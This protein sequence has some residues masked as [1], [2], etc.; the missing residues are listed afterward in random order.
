MAA[1]AAGVPHVY[2]TITGLGY[3]FEA[4]NSSRNAST[5]WAACYTAWRFG[6]GRRFFSESGRHKGFPP[7]GHPRPQPRVLTA[8]GT[9]VDTKRFAP[10][11]LARLFRR[12]P[13]QRVACF[14][15]WWR[16]CLKPRAC[17]NMPK[18][19]ACSMPGT[20]MPAFRCS[21]RRKKASAA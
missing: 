4:D 7:V 10:Q 11:P 3:A 16:A 15:C 9:G 8:R 17:R 1:R 12:W 5:A 20:L 2:A 13:P 19:R 21:A 6:R 18:P 14:F